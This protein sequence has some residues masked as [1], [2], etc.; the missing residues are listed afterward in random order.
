M[1]IG[2]SLFMVGL[3]PVSAVAQ[4]PNKNPIAFPERLKEAL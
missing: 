1:E 3:C 4:K 2:G